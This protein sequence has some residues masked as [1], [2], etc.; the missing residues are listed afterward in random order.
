[1]G[2]LEIDKGVCE[3]KLA[4][5]EKMRILQSSRS[6]TRF[7]ETGTHVALGTCTNRP[8]L[9]RTERTYIVPMLSKALIILDM[10]LENGSLLSIDELSRE[11]GFS[12]SSVY[13]IIRTLSLHGYL[14]AKC[15]KQY[16]LKRRA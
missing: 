4:V 5:T 8:Q 3:M 1:M 11:T 6:D 15:E 2:I 13:R 14:P 9:V 12:R 10:L 7:G 16:Y